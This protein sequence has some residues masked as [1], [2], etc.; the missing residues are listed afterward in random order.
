MADP[1]SKVRVSLDLVVSPVGKVKADG[2]GDFDLDPSFG[3]A[4]AIDYSINQYFF[5]GFSPQLIFGIKGDNSGGNSDSSKELDLL[6]RVGGNAPIADRIQLYGYLAPGYSIVMLPDSIP[7]DN[8]SGFVLGFHA[9]AMFDLTPNV[10]LNAQIGY[11]V[12]F[13]DVTVA[14]TTGDFKTNFLQF[15]LGGGVRL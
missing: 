10:F 12:G 15:G 8:P 11:Q 3:L 5:V 1:N 2:A 9:G 13:Q 6:V 4:P 14:N 7:I